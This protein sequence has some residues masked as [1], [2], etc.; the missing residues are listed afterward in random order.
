ML[1]WSLC[2]TLKGS[3]LMLANSPE[4]LEAMLSNGSRARSAQ[5][6]SSFGFQD[7]TVIRLDRREQAQVC[8]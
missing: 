5:L 3:D 6:K 2:Y 1:G 8:V 4:L 7:L